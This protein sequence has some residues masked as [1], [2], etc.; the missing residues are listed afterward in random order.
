VSC[1]FDFSLAFG[2]LSP[3]VITVGSCVD[4]HGRPS[5]GVR[6]LGG[7]LGKRPGDDHAEK[8]RAAEPDAGGHTLV[9]AALAST[10]ATRAPR[11]STFSDGAGC[12][13]HRGAQT[14]FDGDAPVRS[15][16]SNGFAHLRAALPMQLLDSKV[17]TPR[18]PQGQI[19]E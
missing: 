3:M 17:A 9:P 7:L 12:P 5:G 2:D 11:G 18:W 8:W 15:D 10:V 1:F 16:P 6:P 19:H 13:D 4:R 14:A